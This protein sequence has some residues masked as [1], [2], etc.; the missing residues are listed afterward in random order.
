MKP[1]L[2]TPTVFLDASQAEQPRGSMFNTPGGSFLMLV[3]PHITV[4]TIDYPANSGRLLFSFPSPVE[5]SMILTR[6]R[7]DNFDRFHNRLLLPAYKLR[8]S[9]PVISDFGH[10]SRWPFCSRNVDCQIVLAW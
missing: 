6:R 5:P 3:H 2:S 7:Y 4:A 1:R 8:G 9:T 10:R